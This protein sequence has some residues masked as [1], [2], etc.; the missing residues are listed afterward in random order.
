MV[1]FLACTWLDKTNLFPSPFSIHLLH[2]FLLTQSYVFLSVTCLYLLVNLLNGY[3]C[4]AFD[5][6]KQ[7][8]EFLFRASTV[9]TCAPV[10]TALEGCSSTIRVIPFLGFPYFSRWALFECCSLILKGGGERQSAGKRKPLRPS[11]FS[12]YLVVVVF[13]SSSQLLGT[14]GRRWSEERVVASESGMSCSRSDFPS[15]PCKLSFVG[16]R[17]FF[18]LTAWLKALRKCVLLL[19]IN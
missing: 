1:Q 9:Y 6:T 12:A 19:F 3:V 4:V 17:A 13:M 2:R 5:S 10:C 14:L 18:S 16:K 8:C 15:V 11:G 7:V